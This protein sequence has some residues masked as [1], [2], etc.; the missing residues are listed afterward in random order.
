MSVT[1]CHTSLHSRV[2]VPPESRRTPEA[3]VIHALHCLMART[4]FR[5]PAKVAATSNGITYLQW[6]SQLPLT[7]H[8]ERWIRNFIMTRACTI[9]FIRNFEGINTRSCKPAARPRQSEG[10]LRWPH[11]PAVLPAPECCMEM[12]REQRS[13]RQDR[14]A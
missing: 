12:P 4:C 14:P 11:T 8:T 9:H 13:N 2:Y 3:G 1:T 6:H 5:V 7:Y 10:L